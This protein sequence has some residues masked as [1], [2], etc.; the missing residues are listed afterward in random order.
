MIKGQKKDIDK[1]RKIIVIVMNILY[2]VIWILALLFCVNKVTNSKDILEK[3][4]YTI[5]II[6]LIL[7]TNLIFVY[8]YLMENW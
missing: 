1:A 3:C 6:I 8:E 7:K 2:I 5:M 4:F